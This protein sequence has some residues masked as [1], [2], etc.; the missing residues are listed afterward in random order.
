MGEHGAHNGSKSDIIINFPTS[1]FERTKGLENQK[2]LDKF[3]GDDSW[4]DKVTDRDEFL[5][6][7]MNKL[8]NSFHKQRMQKPYSESIRVGNNSYYYDMILLC[9]DG[10]YVNVWGQ[11]MKNKWNWE[12]PQEMK[13]LLDYL[14]GRETRLD[15]FT[16]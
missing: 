2:C 5:N 7:Y 9:K 11:Y 1:S 15:A 16:Q 8:T 3:F 10:D 6:L 14:K 13:N 4:L 12:N